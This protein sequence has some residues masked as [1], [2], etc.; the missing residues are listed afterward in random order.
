[1]KNTLYVLSSIH[2]FEEYEQFKQQIDILENI[3]KEI[4]SRHQMPARSLHII[5]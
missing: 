2:S 5:F 3:A 4:L 1:M